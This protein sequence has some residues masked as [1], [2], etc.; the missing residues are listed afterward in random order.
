MKINTIQHQA[1][2]PRV[3]KRH[4]LKRN[5]ANDW[6]RCRQ[7]IRLGADRWL[8]F[9]KGHQVGEK[10]GL[11]ADRGQGREHLLDVAARLLN[12]EGQERQGA[13]AQFP[14]DGA[15]DDVDVGRIV[16]HGPDHRQH[17]ARDQ[18]ASG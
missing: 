10:Q 8:H 4:V 17:R 9:K 6:P 7:R 3:T 15:P 1:R 16:S 13:D 2:V 18:L 5:S 12:C 11:I 14:C